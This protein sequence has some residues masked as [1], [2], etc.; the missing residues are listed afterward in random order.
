MK[1]DALPQDPH[2]DPTVPALLWEI[3][4]ERRMEF[5]FEFS[6]IIDLRRWKK[7]EY[8]DTDKN[9]DLLIGTW[10]NFNNEVKKRVEG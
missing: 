4:R 2:R 8:M 1:L 7:L 5:A 10:V 6:R 3:R 9:E